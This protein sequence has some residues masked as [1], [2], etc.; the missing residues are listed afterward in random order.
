[1]SSKRDERTDLPVS[2]VREV[3]HRHVADLCF[4]ELSADDVVDKMIDEAENQAEQAS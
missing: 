3:L 4:A 1:M 2:V